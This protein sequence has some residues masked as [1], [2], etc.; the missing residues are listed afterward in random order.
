MFKASRKLSLAD[1]NFA[2]QL[3]RFLKTFN[4]EDMPEW[5]GRFNLHNRKLVYERFCKDPRD[6]WE[7][8]NYLTDYDPTCFVERLIQRRLLFKHDRKNKRVLRSS[9]AQVAF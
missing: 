4:F 5:A 8:I 7:F 3:A 2:N 1:A 9:R 6:R